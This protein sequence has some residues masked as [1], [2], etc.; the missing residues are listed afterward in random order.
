MRRRGRLRV[1]RRFGLAWE[2]VSTYRKRPDGGEEA[3]WYSGASVLARIGSLADMGQADTSLFEV[4]RAVPTA[5]S[6][7]CGTSSPSQCRP[8]KRGCAHRLGI[9]TG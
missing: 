7:K 1:L 5:W 3:L 4:G 9:D 6:R 8:A 2:T